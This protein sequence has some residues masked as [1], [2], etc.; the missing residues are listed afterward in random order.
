MSSIG[1]STGLK[2][3]LSARYMLDTIGHNIA[4][5]N[6]PGYSRQRVQLGSSLPIQLGSLLIGSGVDAGRVERSID[7]LL[8][9]RINGQRSL[10][11]SLETQRGMLSDFEAVFAEPGENGLGS[12]LDGFFSGLSQLSTA[13][14]D[15]ILRTSAMQSA[16]SLTARFRDLSRSL[17]A[18]STDA[19]ADI[20]S[21]TEE[22]NKL[23]DEI[24][25]LNLK[26][27]ETESV[28]LVA[29]DLR[30]RRDVALGRLSKLVDTTTVAGPN[31]SVRGAMAHAGDVALG[32]G[33]GRCRAGRRSDASRVRACVT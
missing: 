28:G 15:S 9:R 33:E 3:L 19:M 17:A 20:S 23:A 31:G 4:N 10:I 30:D 7:Q 18:A 22:V 24:V 11:G 1:L 2:A 12:L 6:T 16:E 27:G 8:G 21:R 29:N 14:T 25:G 13:P 5:A 26:I 32:G